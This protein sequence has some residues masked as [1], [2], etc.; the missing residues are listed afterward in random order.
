MPHITGLAFADGPAIPHYLKSFADDLTIIFASLASLG[1]VLL[2]LEAF[3]L[4]T[5]VEVNPNS[6]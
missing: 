6:S 3:K 1:T 5:G 4:F 2:L